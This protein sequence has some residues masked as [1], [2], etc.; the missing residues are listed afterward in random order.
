MENNGLVGDL[1]AISL[2]TLGVQVDVHLIAAL[3]D[4]GRDSAGLH[5]DQQRSDVHFPKKCG[6]QKCD[7][8]KVCFISNTGGC[9]ISEDFANLFASLCSQAFPRLSGG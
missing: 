8:R 4:M 2:H 1:W 3:R 6:N 5:A 9:D 7:S